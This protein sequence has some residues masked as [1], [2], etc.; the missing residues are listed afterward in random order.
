MVTALPVDRRQRIAVSALGNAH[1]AWANRLSTARRRRPGRTAG[2]RRRRRS[3]SR[4]HRSRS[5]RWATDTQGLTIGL[6]QALV[7]VAVMATAR[8]AGPAAYAALLR[9][10]NVGGRTRVPMADFR[11]L[12]EGLGHQRVRTYV[13][14]GNAVFGRASSGESPL[15]EGTLAAEIEEAMRERFGF[16]IA[17][18]VRSGG[19]LREVV[20]A[21]PYSEQA[22]EGK[23]VHAVFLSGSPRAG[24]IAAALPS[25]DFRPDEYELGDRVIYLHVPNGLGRSRLAEVL[26]RPAVLQGMVATTRNWNTVTK[27]LEWTTG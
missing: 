3:R 16:P 5:R 8:E 10:V 17:C 23:R 9:G 26:S 6:S 24:D 19:Y 7:I 15:D 1:V 21:N 14:S 4:I 13:N 25:E 12:L 11:D 22:V 20:T 2:R 27:L 18:L